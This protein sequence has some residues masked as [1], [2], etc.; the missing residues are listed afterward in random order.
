MAA[1]VATFRD[2]T[3]PD[4]GMLSFTSHCSR[5]VAGRPGPSRPNSSASGFPSSARRKSIPPRGTV[6]AKRNPRP[7][8]SATVSSSPC[9]SR[10]RKR[11]TLP[12]EPRSA[13]G[14]K[15]SAEPWVTRRP[16]APVASAILAM[17]PRF[18]GSWIPTQTTTVRR[19]TSSHEN[20]GRLATASRPSG[21]SMELMCRKTRSSTPTRSRPRFPNDVR[22]STGRE[23][24]NTMCSNVA[25][26]SIAAWTSFTPSTR[27]RDSRFRARASRRTVL[28]KELDVLS[29]VLTMIL[30]KPFL[31]AMISETP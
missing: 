28:T 25:P 8:S 5:R 23:C 30:R 19:P 18:P 14:P 10:M 3:A 2:S 11:R 24:A 7:F 31:F 26:H 27:K 17:A 13:F 15:G 9:P 16:L 1:T 12:M 22:S 29:I 20:S 4:I 21:E 6:A